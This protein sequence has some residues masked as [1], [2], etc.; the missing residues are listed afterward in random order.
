MKRI[1]RVA[2]SGFRG[3]RQGHVGGLVDVNVI[4]GRNNSGKSSVV[5][6]MLRTAEAISDG[7]PDA[8][9]RPRARKADEE[10][11]GSGALF[12]RDAAA[13][14]VSVESA[15]ESIGV[16]FERNTVAPS[17]RSSGPASRTTCF[18]PSDA[19]NLDI[20]RRLWSDT[21]AGR[22]DKLLARSLSEI[23]GMEVE[24]VQLPPDGRAILL[25]PDHGLPLDAQGD[26]ARAAFRALTVL[27]AMRDA[28]LVLEEPECHQH[29]GSLRRFAL[30]LVKL[31]KTNGV[32]LFVTTHSG[33]CI[34]AFLEASATARSESAVFHFALND[35]TLEAR[36]LDAKT[37][38]TLS[39]TGTDVRYLSLYA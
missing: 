7:A 2:L 6:A 12:Y 18:Y 13:A 10:R 20:E 25:F 34:T 8:V 37:V 38:E 1:D 22:R 39:A 4:V 15:G 17:T 30:A 33:E 16:R 26:G 3:I 28:P 23:F 11:G 9:G 27:G 31:A 5:E 19:R 36:K 32:Q 14:E 21:L 29:P 35:G 24:G